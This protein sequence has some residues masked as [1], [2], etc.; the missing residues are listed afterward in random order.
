MCIHTVRLSYFQA[1][2]W[3]LAAA[4]IVFAVVTGFFDMTPHAAPSLWSN[5]PPEKSRVR[6]TPMRYFTFVWDFLLFLFFWLYDSHMFRLSLWIP[7]NFVL[8]RVLG[9]RQ[10][11]CAVDAPQT[12]RQCK[13]YHYHLMHAASE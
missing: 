1:I 11:T 9:R 2:W 6:Y 10:A 5:N 4:T 3:I 8:Q 13:Q 12:A 7:S